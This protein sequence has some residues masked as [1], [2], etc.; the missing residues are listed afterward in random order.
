MNLFMKGRKKR[1]P[2]KSINSV[3]IRYEA[4]GKGETLVYLQSPFGG[5]NPGA[6]YFAGRMSKFF[7]VIIWDGPN[8]G[9]SSAVLKESASEWHMFCFFL[10]KVLEQL[11]EEKVHLA[12][13]SGGGEMALLFAH[14]YPDRV[15]SV[16]MY[17]PT[18]TTSGIEKE[19]VKARYYDL[20][21]ITHRESME[22]CLKYSQNPPETQFGRISGWI[23]ALLRRNEKLLDGFDAEKLYKLLK[24]W[25]DFFGC[26]GFYKANL[27]EEELAQIDVPVLIAPCADC[28]HPEEIA[29]DLRKYLKNAFYIPS[30]SFRREDEIYGAPWEEHSFGGFAKFV[31][32]CERFLLHLV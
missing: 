1:M 22:A 20:A 17:R 15:K 5:L 16:S 14:L 27:T 4:Y 19:I 21:E 32:D 3:D 8:N 9:Q 13:C 2:V 18:D 26:P 11:H 12:G 30:E 31:D 28:C 6:Y 10:E 23:A 25:G 24:S 29:V 7:H